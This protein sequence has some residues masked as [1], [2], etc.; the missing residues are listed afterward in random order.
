MN[1]LYLSSNVEPNQ[2]T[3]QCEVRINAFYVS[4]IIQNFSSSIMPNFLHIPSILPPLS[5]FSPSK[6]LET[7]ICCP[8][9]VP[10]PSCVVCD[11][12]EVGQLSMATSPSSISQ[13]H[14]LLSIWTID[15]VAGSVLIIMVFLF[16]IFVI[17]KLKLCT[18]N[19]KY[20]IINID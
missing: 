11:A 13:K 7:Y 14:D 2:V 20:I 8:S 16:A 15:V 17:V 10:V 5:Y 19:H 18:V 1:K 12:M 4:H 6:S 9:L 3:K